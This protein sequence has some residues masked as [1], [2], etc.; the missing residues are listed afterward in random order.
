MKRKEDSDRYMMP[1]LYEDE[2]GRM[3]KVK[4]AA[5][6]NTRYLDEEEVFKTEQEIWEEEQ[7]KN[8]SKTGNT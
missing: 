5:L 4:Q 2:T 7:I 8:A 1:D 6:L 3:D